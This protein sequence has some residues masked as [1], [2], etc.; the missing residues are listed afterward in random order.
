MKVGPAYRDVGSLE[1]RPSRDARDG[2]EYIAVIGIDRYR[3]WDRLHNAVSDAR[4]ALSLF[5]GLGF[6]LLA[7][8]LL[9]DDATGDALR[10]LVI[11]S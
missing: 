1:Q 7:P 6:E 2:R 10:R 9:D 3:T 8:P 4:G 11:G 5:A